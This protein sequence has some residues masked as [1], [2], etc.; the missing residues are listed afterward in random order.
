MDGDRLDDLA[1]SLQSRSDF[2]YFL[3]QLSKNISTHPQEWDNY[4]LPI[5]LVALSSWAQD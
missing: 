5:F 1:K 4:D 3:A 2:L